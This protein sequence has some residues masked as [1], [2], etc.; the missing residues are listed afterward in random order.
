MSLVGRNLAKGPSPPTVGIY[1]ATYPTMLIS[2]ATKP[3]HSRRI[4]DL[5]V[6]D[7]SHRSI[8]NT[9]GEVLDTST[10]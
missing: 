7:E 4:L 2:S 1:V 8:Y 5:I 6:I 10:P 9:Y 3:T